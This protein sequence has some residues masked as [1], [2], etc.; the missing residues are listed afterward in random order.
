MKKGCR[1][2]LGSLLKSH[3]GRDGRRGLG[4]AEVIVG[5]FVLATLGLI[6]LMLMPRQREKARTV[7]CQQNLREIGEALRQY[8]QAT[9]ILPTVPEPGERPSPLGALLL[10]LD[11][12]DF[13]GANGPGRKPL[14]RGGEALSAAPVPGFVCPSDPNATAGIHPRRSA[15][16]PAPATPPT[17]ATAPSPPARSPQSPISS[18][19]TASATPPPSPSAWWA[20]AATVRRPPATTRSPRARSPGPPRPSPRAQPGGGMPGRPGWRPTGDRRS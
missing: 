7:A 20:T 9:D 11:L 16:G 15:I 3:A 1:M 12:R 10:E 17:V 18:R 19:A 13:R 2:R 6:L 14:A 5:M 4:A 8:S